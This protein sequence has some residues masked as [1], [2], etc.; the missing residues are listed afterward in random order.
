M[1]LGGRIDISIVFLCIV[2]ILA[3]LLMILHDSYFVQVN[4]TQ[5]RGYLSSP[6]KDKTKIKTKTLE[7]LQG[8][9]ELSSINSYRN[10]GPLRC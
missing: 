4:V 2:K 6:E 3:L 8:A 7:F 10:S 1:K 9:L 5:L